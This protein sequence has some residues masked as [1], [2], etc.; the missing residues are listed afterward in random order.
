MF[1]L[2]VGPK[3]TKIKL[4]SI[5]F[6]LHLTQS[7]TFPTTPLNNLLLNKVSKLRKKTL[8]YPQNKS[9]SFLSLYFS[10]AISQTWRLFPLH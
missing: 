8:F 9:S 2:V 5:V 10:L 1:C 4:Y 3:F 7:I 6:F